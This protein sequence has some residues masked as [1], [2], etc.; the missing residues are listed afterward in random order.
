[1]ADLAAHQ[2][3]LVT[4]GQLRAM[5]LSDNQ[6]RHL[7]ATGALRAVR[8][9]V[10]TLP[11]VPPSW[12]QT[13]RAAVLAAGPGAVVSHATAGAVWQ[14]AHCPRHRPDP[15]AIGVSAGRQ[16]RLDGVAG[17]HRT[18]PEQARR[19]H[20]G[21][22]VT[23]PE[24]TIIDLAATLSDR[25]LGECIDDALRRGLIRL[26]RLH[27]LVAAA[28]GPGRRRT[29]PVRRA[30]AARGVGYDPGANVW[31]Q[32]MDRQ[33]DRHGLP[34]SVRQ[35]TVRVNG[36][37]YRIDRAIPELKI[38]IEWNGHA[39]HGTRSGFDRDS[40]KRADLT[41]A[42]WHMLD[43]TPRSS[44]ERICRAVL[45]AIAQRHTTWTPPTT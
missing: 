16:L 25:Q 34:A 30:P 20:R 22:P 1:M 35:H 32:T 39:T 29:G 26:S 2:H 37:T 15:T 4:A 28:A 6:R 45:A 23:S 42:G 11:G 17:C 44:P 27:A 8:R 24:Q 33:W 38:G 3:S 5:H 43:F 18:L 10:Y 14:L 9:G 19:V 41:A 7:V 13:V 21:I 12:E 40:D 36:R 31:E